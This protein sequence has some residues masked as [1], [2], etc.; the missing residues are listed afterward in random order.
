[1]E[2]EAPRMWTAE[3]AEEGEGEASNASECA[4]LSA[5]GGQQR[6]SLQ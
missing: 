1:M 4:P 5:L 3:E 2:A 6:S